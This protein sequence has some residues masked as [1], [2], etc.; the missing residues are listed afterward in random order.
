[1]DAIFFLQVDEMTS[2]C[3]LVGVAKGRPKGV[4]SAFLRGGGGKQG[5]YIMG[6]RGSHGP[7]K[8]L[9]PEFCRAQ[10]PEKMIKKSKKMKKKMKK[11]YILLVKHAPKCFFLS[12][13]TLIFDLP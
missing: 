1:M 6:S 4:M 2:V 7:P 3:F 10:N 8:L 12:L 5:R 11:K 13:K 9:G